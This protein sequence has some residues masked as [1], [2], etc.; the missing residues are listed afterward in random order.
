V[1]FDLLIR[2]GRVL[3]PSSGLDADR[4]VAISAGRIAAVEEVIDPA[5]AAES[6]DANGLL[7]LPGL[8]DL[9]THVYRHV[10]Y[11]GVDADA[12][13]SASGVTTWLDVGSAGAMTLAGL[14][15]FVARPARTRIYALLNISYL[16]LVAPEYEVANLRYC[17]LDL[18]DRAVAGNLDFVRG[19]KVR[20]GTPTVGDNGV[21][22]L[23][24]ARRAADRW[25]FPLMVHIANAPPAIDEVLP[26]LRSG[27]VITHCF[28]GGSMRIVGADGHL[29]DD[30][31]RA[32]DAGV[33]MDIGHGAGS[34]SFEA[35]EAV[36]AAGYQPTTISTDLHQMSLHGPALV[37]S[38]VDASPLIRVRGDGAPQFDLP[39]CMSKFLALGMPLCDV[40]A[41]AT[42]RPAEVVG[43]GGWLGSLAPGAAADVALFALED[44]SYT[45]HDVHGDTRQGRQLL[46]NRL[47]I[48]AGRVLERTPLPPPPPWVELVS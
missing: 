5:S 34:L 6:I 29:R 11:W 39:T 1:L 19:V 31:K 12:I 37:S 47:T 15:E 44:G 48:V 23:R 28:T 24:L 43:L 22:P 46:R 36:L 32:W 35:A 33:V 16:G 17:D 9:H 3:D 27:D 25:G 30:V 40:V 42:S 18:F 41:A 4:D 13:G 20:M 10:T 21:E 8:V 38:D 45:F 14:R 26:H 7:V 2:G